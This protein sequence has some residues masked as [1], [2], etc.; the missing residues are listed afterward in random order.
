VRRCWRFGQT[1]P[2][3]VD[4][5]ATESEVEIQ[6]NLQRKANQAERMFSS[7]VAHMRDGM[8]IRRFEIF[9]TELEVPSWL[10]S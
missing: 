2:V 10:A 8:T 9:D 4:I 5:I 3:L 7:L 6:H 1:R